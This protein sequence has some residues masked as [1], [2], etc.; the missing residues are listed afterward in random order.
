VVGA[1]QVLIVFYVTIVLLGWMKESG[2]MAGPG[3]MK[4]PFNRRYYLAYARYLIRFF[5]EYQ[6]LGVKFWGMTVQNEPDTGKLDV[7]PFQTM[8]LVRLNQISVLSWQQSFRNF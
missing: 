8:Y 3:Q 7:Y 1:W 2:R 6:K 5:E 4:G